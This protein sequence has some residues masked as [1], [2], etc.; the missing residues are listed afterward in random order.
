VVQPSDASG[1]IARSTVYR[2]TTSRREGVGLPQCPRWW[3]HSTRARLVAAAVTVVVL[4]FVAD[5]LS[6]Q[7]EGRA[8]AHL[9]AVHHWDPVIVVMPTTLPGF[10]AWA[11]G[12]VYEWP[13]LLKALVLQPTC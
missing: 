10:W 12:I 11:G 8:M 2:P 5:P 1:S 13:S 3:L 4:T 6:T 7:G 9:A